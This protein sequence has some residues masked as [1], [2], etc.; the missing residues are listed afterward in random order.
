MVVPSGNVE[1][2]V[3]V[4]E[5]ALRPDK[6]SV[7]FEL[8]ETTAPLDPTASAV[9]EGNVSVGAVRSTFTVTEAEFDKLAWL[10]AVHV[11]VV[12]AC[13]VSVVRVVVVHP[14]DEAIPDSR[15]ETDQ[16]TVTVPLFQ[17]LLLALGVTVGVITGGVMSA[18]TK[19]P[20]IT[21]LPCTVTVVDREEEFVKVID[22]APLLQDEKA[23]PVPELA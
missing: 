12:P 15:S 11:S 16:V 1:P 2:E 18:R 19:L 9:G 7:A 4:H 5:S 8:Y 20:V 10:V 17:P 23:Y 14:E 3:G 13:G 21:P 22:A 6:E